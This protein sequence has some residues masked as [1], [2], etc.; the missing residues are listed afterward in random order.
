MTHVNP[1]QV[2][3][4]LQDAALLVPMYADAKQVGALV[5]GHPSNGIRY[6]PEDMDHLLYPTDQIAE[7][8]FLHSKN[9]ERLDK[10]EQI[11]NATPATKNSVSA[12]L[13]DFALRNIFN[14]AYLADSPLSEMDI[15]RQRL[16]GERK[17]HVERGKAVQAVIL[18]ALEKLR[19]SPEVPHDPVSRDW[20]PYVIL[21]GAYVEEIQN[22]DI[23]SRLYISEGTFNRTRRAAIHSLAQILA[24]MEKLG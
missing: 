14:Y 4:P 20:Y 9:V 12:E 7:A 6:A 3:A 13:V 2:P 1:G 18:E 21:H 15:V 19:P 23:M 10:V 24:E 16:A 8:L 22:R 17:T 11:V 5:L